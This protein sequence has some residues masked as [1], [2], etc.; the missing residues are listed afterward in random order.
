MRTAVNPTDPP[1]Q[2]THLFKRLLNLLYG[3]APLLAR[4]EPVLQREGDHGFNSAVFLPGAGP[5]SLP[6]RVSTFPV[7][8]RAFPLGSRSGHWGCLVSCAEIG[9]RRDPGVSPV[10][11]L[12]PSSPRAR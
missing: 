4:E 3:F 7:R 5:S 9:A 6:P 2:G 1:E 12:P 11:P 8:V 10:L